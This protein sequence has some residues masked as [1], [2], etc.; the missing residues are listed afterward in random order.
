MVEPVARRVPAPAVAWSPYEDN[1]C[2]GGG[3]PTVPATAAFTG[4][5]D[6]TNGTPTSTSIAATSF[7]CAPIAGPVDAPPST[8]PG[9]VPGGR[10]VAAAGGIESEAAHGIEATDGGCGGARS[11]ARDDDVGW[12]V[13]AGEATVGGETCADV[14]S[15]GSSGGGGGGDGDVDESG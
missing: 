13:E 10:R 4:G 11:A 15:D 7:P 2:G 3:A 12:G 9:A 6:P 8:V 1:G 5:L 14:G